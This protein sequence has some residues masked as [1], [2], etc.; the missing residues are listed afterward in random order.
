M[1]NSVQD[2]RHLMRSFGAGFK[3]LREPVQEV[4]G[5]FRQKIHACSVSKVA[6]KPLGNPGLRFGDLSGVKQ[7]DQSTFAF[8][9]PLLP[10]IRPLLNMFRDL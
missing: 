6:K 10:R 3:R 7:A 9:A 4:L 1:Q 8:A 2:R 5:N